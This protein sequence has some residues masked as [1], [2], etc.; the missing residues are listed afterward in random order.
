M[1]VDDELDQRRIGREL[2]LGADDAGGTPDH[3]SMY[4]SKDDRV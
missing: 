1:L 2:E 4:L 3:A